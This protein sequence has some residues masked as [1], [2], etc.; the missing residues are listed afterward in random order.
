MQPGT[1]TST[2]GFAAHARGTRLAEKIPQH[3]LGLLEVGDDAARQGTHDV[4]GLGRSAEHLPGEM[5]HGA[6]AGE[7][8]A[9]GASDGDHRR[10]VEHDPLA[11]HAQERIGRAQIDRHVGAEIAEKSIKHPCGRWGLGFRV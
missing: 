3:R 6:A 7:D 2:R 9:V 10:L 11:D 5:A 4:D 1:A 8:P